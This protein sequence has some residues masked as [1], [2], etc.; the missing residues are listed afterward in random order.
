MEKYGRKLLILIHHLKYDV[1]MWIVIL[2][3]ITQVIRIKIQPQQNLVVVM[4]FYNKDVQYCRF[5]KGKYDIPAL[6]IKV[7]L[8]S[9]S[10]NVRSDTKERSH[11]GHQ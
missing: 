7:I 6:Q 4:L 5:Q 10:S 1:A 3:R 9:Q 8:S 11:K 2:S